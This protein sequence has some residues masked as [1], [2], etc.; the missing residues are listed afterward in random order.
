LVI[1]RKQKR[2]DRCGE[3]TEGNQHEAAF[4]GFRGYCGRWHDYF[5]TGASRACKG[6]DVQPSSVGRQSILGR[7]LWLLE[8][9]N[10]E[11]C[12]KAIPQGSY[13]QPSGGAQSILERPLWL[14]G[15]VKQR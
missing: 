11:D 1:T 14:L 10:C 7:P 15:S 6:S 9:T 13:V 2:E 8:G 4:S 5:G 12:G 3:E